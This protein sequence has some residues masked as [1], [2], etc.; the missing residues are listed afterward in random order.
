MHFGS[1]Q[2][3][4]QLSSNTWLLVLKW[5]CVHNKILLIIPVQITKITCHSYGELIVRLKI[6][7]QM[8]ERMESKMNGSKITRQM[9]VCVMES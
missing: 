6:T 8:D 2:S 9:D 5:N 7:R 1:L 3:Q 4:R